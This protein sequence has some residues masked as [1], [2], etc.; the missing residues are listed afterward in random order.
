LIF[1]S[2]Q[3]VNIINKLSAAS[4]NDKKNVYTID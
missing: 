3:F 1:P 2:Q 4:F